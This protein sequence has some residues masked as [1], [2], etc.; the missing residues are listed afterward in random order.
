MN[1]AE[2]RIDAQKYGLVASMFAINAIVQ[3]MIAENNQRQALGQSM[4]YQ[5][6]SFKIEA[7][8]LGS[9]STQLLQI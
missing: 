8:K 9:L 5:Y 2:I 3:G 7:D 6:E 4:A 1:E